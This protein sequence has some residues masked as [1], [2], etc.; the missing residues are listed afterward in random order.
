MSQSQVVLGAEHPHL[1]RAQSLH[2][3]A[4]VHVL[5]AA[6]ELREVV[7]EVDAAPV[8]R[9]R[10]ERRSREVTL[11][12]RHPQVDVAVGT[13][14]RLGIEPRRRPALGEDRLD[15][16][17]AQDADRGGDAP[18]VQTRVER[19]QAVR[20]LELERRRG[21]GE[22]RATDAPPAERAGAGAHHEPRDVA[23]LARREHGGRRR[24]PPRAGQ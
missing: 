9:A 24:R 6:P 23:Q 20:L 5:V 1:D 17:G 10:A 22:P 15:A 4:L 18:V 14:P 11:L 21:G 16:R 3:R 13:Q 8:A 2:A 19:L 7:V 12:R